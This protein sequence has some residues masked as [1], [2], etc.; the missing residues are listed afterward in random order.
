MRKD[1]IC[2]PNNLIPGVKKNS[3]YCF[4]VGPIKGSD[5]W[6]FT[7]PEIDGITWINPRRPEK[8]EGELPQEEWLKQVNWET[9]GLRISDVVL[10]WIPKAIEENVSNY[11][12]TTRSEITEVLARRKKVII[13]IEDNIAGKRYLVEKAKQYGINVVHNSLDG[14]LDELKLWYKNRGADTFFTSDTHFNQQR[15]L[16]LSQRPFRDLDDMNW[17]LIENWNRVVT[18]TS[19]IFIIGDFGDYNYLKYLNGQPVVIFGNYEFKEM[20]EKKMDTVDYSDWLKSL[21]VSN[22]HF[23][24]A[25]CTINSKKNDFVEEVKLFHEPHKYYEGPRYKFGVL[26]HCHQVMIRKFKDG[27]YGFNVGVDCNNYAPV[28]EDKVAFYLNAM[29]KYYDYETWI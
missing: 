28:N 24:Y 3:T 26:G 12:K 25:I 7:V 22:V 17:S 21:G 8:I 23:N 27:G 19:K 11:A 18:P 29:K 2:A 4:L 6:Q 10:V 1:M 13:G 20:D 5:K 9:R 14:C 16:E 15:T